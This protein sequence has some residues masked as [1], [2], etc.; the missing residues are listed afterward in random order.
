MDPFTTILPLIVFLFDCDIRRVYRRRELYLLTLAKFLAWGIFYAFL[1]IGSQ[2]QM[3][4]GQLGDHDDLVRVCNFMFLIWPCVGIVY[5]YCL[6]KFNWF[7][8]ALPRDPRMGGMM[9]DNEE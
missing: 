3:T 9:P 4:L 2:M 5:S 6:C 8:I 1:G 7:S